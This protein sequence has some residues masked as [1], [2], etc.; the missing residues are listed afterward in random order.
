[1][2][3]REKAYVLDIEKVFKGLKIAIS[4]SLLFSA[5]LILMTLDEES[6]IKALNSVS[7][8][9]L[10]QIF[11]LLIINFI[12]AGLGFKIMVSATGNYIKLFDGIKLFLAGAFISNVT[13]M[14]TGGGPFQIYFLHK[15][16]INLGQ[17]TMVILTQFILRIFFFTIM[18]LFF[19]IFFNDAISPGILPDYIFYIGF[20]TGFI[21]AIS[22]ILL[23]IIPSI[24]VQFINLLFRIEKIKAFVQ[25][26]YKIKRLIVKGREE[27][28]EF[29]KSM[30]LLANHKFKVL[31]AIISTVIYWS[32]L[33][34]IIPVILKG[35][36]YEPYYLKSYVMQT[37]FNMVIPYMPTPG[38]SGVAEVGF[39]SIFIAFIPKGIIGIV[40]FLWR[41]ITFYFIL[42]IGGFFALKELGWKRRKSNG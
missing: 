34:L 14:A 21:L 1:M 37:I 38:A 42:I 39:A 32:S 11:G 2:A 4:I 3:E 8:F 35:L 23:S 36:G 15:K 16:G 19:L 13:P 30:E 18:S 22:L 17:S 28:R 31:F 20:G 26:N 6:L 29:H 24:S 41:F 40:T 9:A 7:I 27:L 5:I 10:L 25:K 12:A 33:F